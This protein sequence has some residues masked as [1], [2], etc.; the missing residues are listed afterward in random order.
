VVPEPQH[1]ERIGDEPPIAHSI[2][3][4]LRVL[5]TIDFDYEP[6]VIAREIGDKSAGRNLASEL[7]IGK[8]AIPQCVPELALGIG[9]ARAQRA[10][11]QLPQGPLT[12]PLASLASTLSRKGRGCP[13]QR[14]AQRVP[15]AAFAGHGATS[16]V[17]PSLESFS[18]TPMVASSSRMRSDSAKFFA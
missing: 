6:R 13:S 3:R 9:Q 4:R 5:S 8:P 2:A 7:E 17:V 16:Q 10:S 12:R 1:A 11:A 14:P 18:T 15:I